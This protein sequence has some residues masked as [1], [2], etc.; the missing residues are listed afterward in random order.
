[1][2][3]EGEVVQI[4]ERTAGPREFHTFFV[5]EHERRLLQQR[6]YAPE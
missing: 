1:M 4:P 2:Q 3:A 6:P 5:E